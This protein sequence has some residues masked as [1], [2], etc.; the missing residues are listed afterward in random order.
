M[1]GRRDVLDQL[2]QLIAVD[3]RAWSRRQI[4]PHRKRAR[5]YLLGQPCAASH[6]LDEVC[7]AA[8]HAC[9]ARVDKPFERRGVAR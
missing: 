4:F 1:L 7:E 9:S 6:I 5:V 8:D 3:D 2:Q